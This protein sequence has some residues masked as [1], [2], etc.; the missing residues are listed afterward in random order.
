MC[1]I[2]T[3]VYDRCVRTEIYKP[4]FTQFKRYAVPTELIFIFITGYR[5]L[6]SPAIIYVAYGN[7]CV[8]CRIQFNQTKTIYCN[9]FLSWS[10][11]YILF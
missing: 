7:E 1:Y 9:R 10:Y 2:E 4:D 5:R 8:I 11:C 6:T 3:G